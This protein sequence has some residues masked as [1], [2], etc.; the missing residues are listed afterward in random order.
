MCIR[1]R[2]GLIG[3]GSGTAEFWNGGEIA[4][5]GFVLKSVAE[6]NGALGHTRIYGSPLKIGD[7][8]PSN[9][10]ACHLKTHPGSTKRA[11]VYRILRDRVRGASRSS[12]WEAC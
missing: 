8:N 7:F 6:D 12:F 5:A 3:S 10:S 4:G 1:S 11:A 9:L 2:I